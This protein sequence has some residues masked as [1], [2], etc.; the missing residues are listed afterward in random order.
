[1]TPTRLC[2]EDGTV[3]TLDVASWSAGADRL[4]G[5]EAVSDWFPWAPLG[6]WVVGRAAA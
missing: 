2:G 5:G 6:A 3:V 1:M 4:E